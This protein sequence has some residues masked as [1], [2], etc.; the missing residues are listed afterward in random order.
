MFNTIK[1][2]LL[3]AVTV[4]TLAACSNNE[5]VLTETT[6]KIT[7]M[8]KS[9]Y[10]LTYFQNIFGGDLIKLGGKLYTLVDADGYINQGDEVKVIL[11]GDDVRS[12][13][14]LLT[15]ELQEYSRCFSPQKVK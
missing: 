12:V 7:F 14:Q 3:A 11:V 13:C 8:D 15:D 1:N 5:V 10:H 2:I 4:S 6:E 9:P